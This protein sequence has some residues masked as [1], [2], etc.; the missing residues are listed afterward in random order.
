LRLIE[1]VL[2]F[3]HNERGALSG[4]QFDVE[5]IWNGGHQEP[6]YA[7]VFLDKR[8]RPSGPTY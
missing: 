2:K 5:V 8:A 7:G 1:E 3:R 6:D 4:P